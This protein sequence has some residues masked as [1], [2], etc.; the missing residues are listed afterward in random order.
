MAGLE[1]IFRADVGNGQDLHLIRARHGRI[2]NRARDVDQSRMRDPGAVVAERRFALFVGAHFRQRI[3]IGHRIVTIGNLCGH[4]AHGQNAAPVAGLNQARGVTVEERCAHADLAA[5]GQHETG[6]PVQGFDG[7]E[8]V[9][10]A[11][12]IQADDACAQGVDDFIH[13]ECGRQGFD[14]HGDFDPAFRQRQMF[15]KE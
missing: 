1:Q 2:E 10:P 14:Q 3:F 15:F 6:L 13:L 7:G 4:A 11:S 8:D 12:A 9:I 5:F